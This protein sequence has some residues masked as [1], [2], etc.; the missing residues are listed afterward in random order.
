[1]LFSLC[2]KLQFK[3]FHAV[4]LQ[5]QQQQTGKEDKWTSEWGS[6]VTKG[7]S[8]GRGKD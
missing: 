6:R 4:K 2:R 1:M 8:T 3:E 7:E 5:Q